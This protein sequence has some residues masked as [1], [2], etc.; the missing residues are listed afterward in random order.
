VNLSSTQRDAENTEG[1][2][3]RD[4]ETQRVSV[5]RCLRG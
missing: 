2:G 5:S 3:H 1:K 4:T